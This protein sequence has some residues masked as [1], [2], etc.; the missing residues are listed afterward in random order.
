MVVPPMLTEAIPVD[1]V[2]PMGADDA[3]S[4]VLIISRNNTDFPVPE[5]RL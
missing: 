5:M 1:A 2:I 3:A 4:S